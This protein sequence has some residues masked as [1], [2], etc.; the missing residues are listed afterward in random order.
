[1]RMN[2]YLFKTLS[3]SLVL[4]TV[5][6]LYALNFSQVAG[7]PHVEGLFLLVF[8]GIYRS[9][10][11]N[12][13]QFLIFC[14][15]QFLFILIL[16]GYM[17]EDFKISAVYVFT[18]NYSRRK[19]FLEKSKHLFL[20]SITYVLM[21]LVVIYL[22]GKFTVHPLN[23]DAF[24]LI[25]TWQF[26]AMILLNFFF[27]MSANLLVLKLGS[28]IGLLSTYVFCIAL[29]TL[30][31]IDSKTSRALFA[32]VNPVSNAMLIWHDHSLIIQFYEDFMLGFIK[33]FR[34]SFSLIYLLVLNLFLILGGAVIT[35]NADIINFEKEA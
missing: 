18:R 12:L 13:I 1:M 35:N 6:G 9:D 8:G 11:V 29:Y 34:L 21:Q 19:W 23:Q 2:R 32:K 5:S 3:L 10:S 33:D 26:A 16:A 25:V 24:L 17:Y 27:I 14:V 28:S 20:Y 22:F 15:P 7:Y 4:S 30:V 31:L